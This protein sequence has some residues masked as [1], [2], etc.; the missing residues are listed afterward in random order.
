MSPVIC[1]WP[2]DNLTGRRSQARSRVWG[3]LGVVNLRVQ[4]PPPPG[5]GERRAHSARAS[6]GRGGPPRPTTPPS[7]AF[8]HCGPWRGGRPQRAPSN[9]RP[10]RPRLS[11]PLAPRRL[12]RSRWLAPAPALARRLLPGASLASRAAVQALPARHWHCHRVNT[13]LRRQYVVAGRT[14]HPRRGSPG[15]PC[16]SG[17]GGGRCSSRSPAASASLRRSPRRC[18]R[19]TLRGTLLGLGSRMRV[20][21]AGGLTCLARE[22]HAIYVL[23]G[24]Y[25]P[26]RQRRRRPHAHVVATTTPR[27]CWVGGRGGA[28]VSR[29]A[30]NSEKRLATP[31]CCWAGV[32]H[33]SR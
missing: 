24:I 22:R 6:D 17:T 18:H 12:H 15:S 30:E 29:S 16:P 19:R 10:C 13:R 20:R 31:H 23:A 5:R 9:P 21:G 14:F 28:D 32:L 2:A 27:R 3:C 7:P 26:A 11:A 4:S 25:Q 1:C 8:P 33:S